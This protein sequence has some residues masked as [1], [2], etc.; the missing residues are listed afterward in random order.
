MKVGSIVCLVLFVLA[1]GLFLL[2]MWFSIMEA[3]SFVK[4]MVTLVVL[5]VVALGI[6]L[7]KKE[8]V[9]EKKM[10]DSGYID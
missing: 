8:Y 6:T 9:D 4:T 1:A 7:V 10:K 5:F 3:E 2:Q